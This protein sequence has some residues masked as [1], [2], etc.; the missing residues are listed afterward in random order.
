MPAGQSTSKIHSVSR[1]IQP[2][3]FL[4]P[5]ND[6]VSGRREKTQTKR[7]IPAGQDLGPDVTPG[8]DIATA[9]GL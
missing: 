7:R 5:I 6:N 4:S 9:D 3:Q 8:A 2:D 1:Y